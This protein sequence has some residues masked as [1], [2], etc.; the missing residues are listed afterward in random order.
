MRQ[1]W[2]FL[3]AAL[4]GW[5]ALVAQNVPTVRLTTPLATFPETFNEITAVR[6]LRDGRVIVVD[7]RELA[8]V[9]VDFKSGKA[10]P[11]G[12]KGTGPGEYEWPARLLPLAGD[13]TALHD[14]TSR[15]HM[16]IHP[17]GTPGA[18]IDTREGVSGP[19]AALALQ[20]RFSDA[21]GRFYTQTQPVRFNSDGKR[22]LTDS[23]AIERWALRAARRD[24][25]A[26]IAVE[27]DPSRRLLPSG[28]VV[29]Q[30]RSI[31]Y[32]SGT[33]WNVTPDGRVIIVHADPYRVDVVQPDGRVVRGAPIPFTRIKVTEAHRREFQAEVNR[34]RMSMRMERGGS[35]TIGLQRMP[36]DNSTWEFPEYLPPFWYEALYIASDGTAWVQRLTEA[37][38]PP[39]FDV[40][41]S[42]RLVRR[43]VLAPRA[44]VV[45]FGRD[46][47]YVV[48]LDEDDLQ[49]LQR[50]SLK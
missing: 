43:V 26:W 40:I 24:T 2:W 48:Q 37:G 32:R 3:G 44:K 39:A 14:N 27:P 29:T 4:A 9:L 41:E 35:R 11:I 16:L 23:F 12:R 33:Q 46:V 36:P 28:G 8:V 34:P 17:D 5:Q 13:S 6:E 18:E 45:G 10:T 49:T 38:A 15:T 21:R 1:P 42:G 25:V 50:F 19:L 47:V 22:E 31:A 7:Q 30:P 20:A